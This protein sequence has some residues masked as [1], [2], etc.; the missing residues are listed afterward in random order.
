MKDRMRDREMNL[1]TFN[2]GVSAILVETDENT[3][4]F[5]PKTRDCRFKDETQD[6]LIFEEY[7]IDKCY[8]EC[9]LKIV[10][11]KCDCIPWNFP[12][13]PN[14]TICSP[15]KNLCFEEFMST[16]SEEITYQD[17]NCLPNCNRIQ[18]DFELTDIES[19]GIPYSSGKFM[20]KLFDGDLRNYVQ[21][22]E[23][24]LW[25]P[26]VSYFKFDGFLIETGEFNKIKK[27]MFKDWNVV[28]VYFKSN[29][30]WKINYKSKISFGGVLSNA[31]GTLGL[32]LGISIIS[33]VEIFTCIL[34]LV[35]RA[36]YDM[37]K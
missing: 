37:K 23:N 14:S 13:F 8:L 26:L 9:R 2:I 3:R 16:I 18:Y 1:K 10:E 20:E 19:V 24:R 4:N 12:S 25:D 33:I 30:V 21:D 28:N 15:L 29:T 5:D 6:L 36:C 34:S 35:T 17:C 7:S 11:E 31:G 27:R 32:F 22:P